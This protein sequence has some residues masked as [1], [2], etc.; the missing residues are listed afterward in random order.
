MSDFI[1]KVNELKK[2]AT[3]I[4]QALNNLEETD[5]TIETINELNKKTIELKTNYEQIISILQKVEVAKKSVEPLENIKRSVE[6]I[7]TTI[8]GVKKNIAYFEKMQEKFAELEKLDIETQLNKIEE[9]Y[10]KVS[11]FSEK[12]SLADNFF[13]T[14]NSINTKLENI[15]KKIPKQFIPR[16]PFPVGQV[17]VKRPGVV[18]KPNPLTNILQKQ[19]IKSIFTPKKEEKK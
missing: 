13:N 9:F 10:N 2:Y 4:S 18:P 15:E 11:A 8:Q 7:N 6:S 16:P 3:E 19:T 14:L 5:L 1:N 17:Q 12:I